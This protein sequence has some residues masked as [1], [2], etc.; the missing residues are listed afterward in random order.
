MCNLKGEWDEELVALAG[1]KQHML[2]RIVDSFS[3]VA[4]VS[5]GPLTG[6]EIRSILGDQ[7]SSSYAH[8]LKKNQMKITYGTGCFMLMNIGKEPIIHPS[9][10]TTILFKHKG[11]IEYA[12]EGAVECGGG[13]I[14]WAKRA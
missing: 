6:V 12:F 8:E 7:Q 2:P 13:T 14:N 9:F 11:H 10:I 4:T 5:K 1:I 3:L